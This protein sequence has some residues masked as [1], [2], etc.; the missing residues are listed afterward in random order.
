M[1]GDFNLKY[2][3]NHATKIERYEKN[4]LMDR[5]RIA[6]IELVMEGEAQ[7]DTNEVFFEVFFLTMRMTTVELTSL[8]D[9]IIF[10]FF[11]TFNIFAIILFH[12]I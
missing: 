4:I 5:D 7:E 10:I 8:Y 1:Q 11:L 6:K 9:I 12:L 3:G 2:N